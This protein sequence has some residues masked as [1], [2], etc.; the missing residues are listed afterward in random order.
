MGNLT[1]TKQKILVIDDEESIRDAFDLALMDEYEV[2]TASNGSAGVELALECAPDL[3][4]LDLKMPGLNGV[5][6]LRHLRSEGIECVVYIVT[7]FIPE[8]LDQLAEAA[9][10][11]LV[12]GLS[13]K[14][15]VRDQIREIAAG[16]LEN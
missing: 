2:F 7:A 6:T 5:Q 15:L 16:I 3:I 11:G 14:P 8:F 9:K 13:Q 1:V 12:F 10:E 4:F